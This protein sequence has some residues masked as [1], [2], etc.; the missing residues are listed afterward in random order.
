MFALLMNGTS[1]LWAPYTWN[2]IGLLWETSISAASWAFIIWAYI[3]ISLGFFCIYQGLPSNLVVWR[4]DDMIYNQINLIFA[5]NM[6]AGSAWVPVWLMGDMWSFIV[7]DVLV[8]IMWV[9]AMAMMVIANRNKVWW[10]E[11]PL[12]RMPLTVYAGWL[13]S[14]TI[15]NTTI[16]LKTWGINDNPDGRGWTFMDFMMF[17]DEEAWGIIVLWAAF[18]IYQFVSWEERNPLYGTVFTWALSAILEE[19]LRQRPE[20]EYL[21]INATVILGVH[22]ISLICLTTYLVFEEL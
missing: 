6:M 2:G 20:H 18:M 1:Q 9:T 15:L 14:A 17:I 21:I 16:M 4:S 19:T 10:L 8:W 3:Y 11:V 12:V 5:I 7:S 13:T 22:V